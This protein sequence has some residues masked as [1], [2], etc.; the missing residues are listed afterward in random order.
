MNQTML[1]TTRNQNFHF[2]VCKWHG[3]HENVLIFFLNTN[4]RVS[5]SALT[6]NN[7]VKIMSRYFCVSDFPFESI[8]STESPADNGIAWA[9]MFSVSS[10]F[11]LEKFSF[12]RSKK[13]FKNEKIGQFTE[14]WFLVWE[15][16]NRLYWF[17]FFEKIFIF[18]II[19]LDKHS[20]WTS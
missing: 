16:S 1:Q 20:N 5:I 12:K 18:E 19:C 9:D 11:R 3:K 4:T 8:P 6:V 10:G 14:I 13:E 2:N 7:S 17:I 15:I